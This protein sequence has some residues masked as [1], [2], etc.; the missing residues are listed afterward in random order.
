MTKKQKRLIFIGLSIAFIV[1]EWGELT[2]DSIIKLALAMVG[3]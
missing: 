2:A 3:I 1:S